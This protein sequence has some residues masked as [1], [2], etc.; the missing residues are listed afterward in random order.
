MY[1]SLDI[2]R[3]YTV[4]VFKLNLVLMY[5]CT[6]IYIYQYLYEMYTLQVEHTLVPQA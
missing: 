3:Y 4:L 6:S 5:F 1:T 2:L